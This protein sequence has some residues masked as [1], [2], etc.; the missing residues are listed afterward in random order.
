[1]PTP[2]R[3]TVRFDM[4]GMSGQ[5]VSA[6]VQAVGEKL[7]EIGKPPHPPSLPPSRMDG[8]LGFKD[9]RFAVGFYPS[10][11][12]E[13][14]RRHAAGAALSG[15]QTRKPP[16]PYARGLQFEKMNPLNILLIVGVCGKHL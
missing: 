3:L 13:S 4:T 8:A 5:L 12:T 7:G 2:Q 15:T 16:R 1:M 14:K 6:A 9:E 11:A 10:G